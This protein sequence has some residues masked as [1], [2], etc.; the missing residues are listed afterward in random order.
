[1]ALVREVEQRRRAEQELRASEEQLL[2]MQ[3]MDAIGRVAGGVAHDFNNMLSVILTYAQLLDLDSDPHQSSE[4][5]GEIQRA[6]TRAA[7]LTKQLLAF[8]RQQVLRP[9][10][11][12]LSAVVADMAPMLRRMIGEH[13]ELKTILT[14]KLEGV[15][16]DRGQLEQVILNL[17]VNARD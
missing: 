17:V 7:T 1:A 13:I 2:Q 4:E 9:A 14:P 6:A 10:I 15:R 5:L 12:S 16:L 3:K 11:L 8:S